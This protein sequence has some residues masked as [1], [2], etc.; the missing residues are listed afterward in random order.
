MR[1]AMTTT[2]VLFIFPHAPV[3]RTGHHARWGVSVNTALTYLHVNEASVHMCV[4]N[5]LHVFEC[6]V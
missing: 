1:I 6:A 5:N 3:T 2:A 4:K